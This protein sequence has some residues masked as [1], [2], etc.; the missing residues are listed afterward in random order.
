MAEEVID[1]LKKRVEKECKALGS[2]ASSFEGGDR[3][4]ELRRRVEAPCEALSVL[5]FG[6]G[7][8]GEGFALSWPETRGLFLQ[9]LEFKRYEPR[10]A[11]NMLSYL[12]RIVKNPI[13][14]PIDVMQLFSPLTAGQESFE[15]GV[16]GLVQL[17]RD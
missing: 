15:Q 5:A 17:F 6:G 3:L 9:Y 7:E 14:A 4:E 2:L 8:V 10:N 13:R 11:R 12:D 16:K 1:R